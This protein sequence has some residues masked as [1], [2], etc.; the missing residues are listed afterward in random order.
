MFAQLY[1]KFPN[2]KKKVE[3]KSSVTA[4]LQR[5]GINWEPPYPEG[6]DESSLKNHIEYMQNEWSKR[7]PDWEKIKKRMML[8]LPARRRMIANNCNFHCK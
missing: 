1:E 6:E 8:T 3:H 7:S 2:K 5:G 4:L